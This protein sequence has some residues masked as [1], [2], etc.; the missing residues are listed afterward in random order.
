MKYLAVG[1]ALAPPLQLEQ[2]GRAVAV[3]DAVGGGDGDGLREQFKRFF[4]AAFGII[5]GAL[6]SS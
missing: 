4:I 1:N 5:L 3:E 2:G 6:Q